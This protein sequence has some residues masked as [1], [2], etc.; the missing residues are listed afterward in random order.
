MTDLGRSEWLWQIVDRAE[1]DRFNGSVDRC[2]RGDDD[3]REPRARREQV[4]QQNHPTLAAELE[5]EERE[6]EWPAIECGHRALAVARA[7]DDAPHALE[8]QRERAADV[9]VIIDDQHG[10]RG[11]C[12]LRLYHLDYI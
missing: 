3:D 6:I 8:T 10:R 9:L 12:G 4:R 5:V 2:L 11:R 1:L 7:R